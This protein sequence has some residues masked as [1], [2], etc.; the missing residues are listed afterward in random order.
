MEKNFVFMSKLKELY[1]RVF[2][3]I[4]SENNINIE[5][6]ND[7][8]L[9]IFDSIDYYPKSEKVVYFYK[10]NQLDNWIYRLDLKDLDDIPEA[11]QNE[12]SIHMKDLKHLFLNE[13]LKA[14]FYIFYDILEYNEDNE[15][16]GY[17]YKKYDDR[18]REINEV[19]DTVDLP[20]DFKFIS[21]KEMNL[22]DCSRNT[23]IGA[24]FKEFIYKPKS[25]LS[26]L[27]DLPKNIIKDFHEFIVS[28]RLSNKDI[29]KL[30][31]I[32]KRVSDF[33]S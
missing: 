7:L 5:L 19:K 4:I 32:I 22:I 13:K 6:I 28:K 10:E 21:F 18:V 16:Y 20:D 27:N 25:D 8:F 9:K 12:E 31:N 2:N 26:Y 11:K 15:D 29:E 24:A 1:E 17:M 33:S 14:H 3:D 30:K 23:C